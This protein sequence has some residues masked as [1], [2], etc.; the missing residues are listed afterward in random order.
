MAEAE[1]AECDIIMSYMPAQMTKEEIAQIIVDAIA[2]TGASSV[3]DMGKVMGVVRPALVGK[4]DMAEVSA[5]I[6]EKL[7]G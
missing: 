4:A 3:K 5:I 1:Q 6:K 2:S 7:S